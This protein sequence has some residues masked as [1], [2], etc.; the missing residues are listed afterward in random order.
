MQD[1]GG[2]WGELQSA[3]RAA[4]LG[5]SALSAAVLLSG[6]GKPPAPPVTAPPVGT[7]DPSPSN[8][9]GSPVGVPEAPPGLSTL[10]PAGIPTTLPAAPPVVVPALPQP[11]PG[12][13]T[14]PTFATPVPA[15]AP[16]CGSA[17]PDGA[18]VVAV[19]QGTTGIP[20]RTLKAVAG[21][22]CANGW[23]F[24]TIDVVPRAGEKRFE[25]MF[26]VTTGKPAALTLVEAGTN[27]CSQQ[28]RQ[29]APTDIRILACGA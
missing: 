5:I 8:S 21:P 16:L 22:F 23:Q 24:T 27:V 15:T 26:V 1:R 25:P 10:P 11:P 4:L 20:D 28:V 17:G 3:F 12:A 2:C 19:V 9:A 29:D 14:T 6:C 18:Q 13:G 7:G